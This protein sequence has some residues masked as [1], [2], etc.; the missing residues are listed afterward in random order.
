M[1][2]ADALCEFEDLDGDLINSALEVTLRD[3]DTVETTVYQ[4]PR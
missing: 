1:L 2:A 3:N 4:L